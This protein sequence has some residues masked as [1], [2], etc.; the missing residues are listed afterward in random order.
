MG[1]NM[2]VVERS[3]ETN[4]A[5][6]TENKGEDGLDLKKSTAIKQNALLKGLEALA[7][8]YQLGFD[9]QNLYK[10]MQFFEMLA[11]KYAKCFKM[12]RKKE[13]VL[14]ELVDHLS[15]VNRIIEKY[16]YQKNTTIQILLDIQKEYNWLP[17]HI[18]LWV[19]RQLQVPYASLLTLANF[20]EVLSLV[21]RGDHHVHVCQ[22][23]ACHVRGSSELM[24][25]VASL[26]E[27]QPG[28][29]DNTQT[30]TL[31]SVHCLGCCAL[32]PVIKINDQYMKNPSMS[33]L[34]KIFQTLLKK[35]GN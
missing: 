28:E 16:K 15:T 26:L 31:D 30:F 9:G 11:Q 5:P 33:A 18:L 3:V 8:F 34:K 17:Q 29:T 27:I 7:A 19:S 25:R 6:A 14:K 32:A 1:V 12:E 21:P 22:G 23:T 13:E 2:K 35:R 20:Y 4:S 10:E 24:Q